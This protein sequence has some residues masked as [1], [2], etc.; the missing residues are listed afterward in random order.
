MQFGTRGGRG[1]K[2]GLHG[3]LPIQPMSLWHAH[4]NSRN[5]RIIINHRFDSCAQSSQS[6]ESWLQTVCKVC[7]GLTKPQE[8]GIT[9]VFLPREMLGH[10]SHLQ[11]T[12]YASKE[13]YAS[14]TSSGIALQYD[15]P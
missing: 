2:K 11:L 5:V 9:S 10:P 13:G 15:L 12:S 7:G 1:K 3:D 4:M 8:R 6:I 14:L